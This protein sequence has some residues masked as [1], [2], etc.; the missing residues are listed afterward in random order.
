[1]ILSAW[2]WSWQSFFMK[3]S[4]EQYTEEISLSDIR[5]HTDINP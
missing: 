5:N 2:P 4:Q 1:M 3:S